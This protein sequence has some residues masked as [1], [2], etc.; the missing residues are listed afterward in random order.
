MNQ[1]FENLYGDA[2]ETTGNS[3]T[4]RVSGFALTMYELNDKDSLELRFT[5]TFDSGKSIEI[6]NWV[7]PI[8]PEKVQV[9]EGK[10]QSECVKNE[11]M[12]QNKLIKNLICNYVSVEDYEAAM[13]SFTPQGS[14]LDQFKAFVELTKGLLPDNFN[15]VT[16]DL[17]VG[18]KS[19]G[20]YSFPNKLGW[21]KDK[22][23]HRP[24]FT[25]DPDTQLM[26]LPNNLS[27]EKPVPVAELEEADV[28]DDF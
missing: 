23:R 16:G 5:K 3:M 20:Y 18:Y 17:M 2:Q 27:L 28:D 1:E 12:K 14:L 9:W 6:R 11:V 10:T 7:N 13:K 24:F 22:K 8:D 4:G 21:D 15:E 25:T 26:D 19:N